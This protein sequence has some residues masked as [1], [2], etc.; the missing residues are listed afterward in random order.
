MTKGLL[1]FN[2]KEVIGDLDEKKFSKPRYNY[3]M[4]HKKF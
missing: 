4:N 2:Q 3:W 1:L